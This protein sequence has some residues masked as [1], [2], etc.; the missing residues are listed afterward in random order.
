[1]FLTF[2]IIKPLYSLEFNLT[3]CFDL[4]EILFFIQKKEMNVIAVKVMAHTV[5]FMVVLR[6]VQ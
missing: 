5:L 4:N 3:F 2:N 1:L 6:D